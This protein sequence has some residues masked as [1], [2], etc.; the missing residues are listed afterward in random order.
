MPYRWALALIGLIVGLV[1]PVHGAVAGEATDQLKSDIS[2]L[3][4]LVSQGPDQPAGRDA[5]ARRAIVDRMFDWS[6]MAQASLRDHWG[7]LSPADRTEFTRLFADLFARAYLTRVHLVDASKFQYLGETVTGDRGTVKT[8]IVTKRGTGL[9]VD[10]IVRATPA[11]RWQI[12]D[13][14]VE[15]TSLV[16]NYRVQ[17]D[18]IIAKSSYGE[19]A[20]RLRAATK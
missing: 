13:V 6:A 11:R 2:E 20:V 18:T 17:F 9:D 12:Q 16:D 8:K 10:Y 1:A 3:Y 14:Q 19:L 7:Q 15:S 4:K 5:Q